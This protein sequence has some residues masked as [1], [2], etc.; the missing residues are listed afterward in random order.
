M[1]RWQPTCLNAWGARRMKTMSGQSIAMTT[2]EDSSTGTKRS[3]EEQPVPV[4]TNLQAE[5]NVSLQYSKSPSSQS[6][7]DISSLFLCTT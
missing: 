7:S 6:F 5:C 2:D 4:D 3:K 1:M